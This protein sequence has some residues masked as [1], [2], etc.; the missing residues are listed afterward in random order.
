MRPRRALALAATSALGVGLLAGAGTSSPAEAAPAQITLQYSCTYPLI[1]AQ[2][3]SVAITVGI[4]DHAQV[5]VPMPPFDVKA[6]STVSANTTSGLSL[7][8]AKTIE[9]KA[10]SHVSVTA[11]QVDLPDVQVPA[12][13]AK[14]AVPSSGAFDLVATGQT[15][16]LTFPQAGTG[17]IKIGALDL[18]MTARNTA[19]DPIALPGGKP[20]GSFD[21]PC[22]LKPG[23]N[24][25]LATFSIVADPG[26][27]NKAPTATDVAATATTATAVQV[28]LKGQDADGDPLTYTVSTPAHGTA[29]VSGATATYKS[30]AGYAGA[31]SFT[32]TVSDGKAT[33]AATVNVTVNST[34][35][36]NQAPKADPVTATTTKD[37]AVQVPLKGSDPDGDALTY[38]VTAPAHGTATVTGSTASYKP[39]TGYTGSDSFTYKV[40]D[41]KGGTASNTVSVTVNPGTSS[42]INYKFK[43]A[44][45]SLIKAANGTVPLNGSIAAVFDLATSKFEG[46][47]A[48]DD[49]TGNFT[50]LGLMPATTKI[51][52]QKVG[53]TKGLISRGHLVSVS[54]MYVVLKSVSVLGF[55]V[56]GG[57]NCKT[58]T[59][60]KIRLESKA[61]PFNPLMGGPI[62]G[63]YTLPALN[64]KCGLLGGLISTLMSGPDNSVT[65][66]LTPSS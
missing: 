56:G 46:D 27:V 50:I 51:A 43:L 29:T 48:I 16:S 18:N 40:A 44:G 11:P 62:T 38:T 10:I 19:G 32:Y 58:V 21:A 3:L 65:A 37:T 7:I 30:A 23:Q 47:L 31:D 66:N 5:G 54:S 53:K 24:T 34:P 22:S 42:G 1:G 57:P 45:S 17:T 20:D 28:Q 55:Q 35:P 64:D 60:A 49:T 41:G 39:V 9:G 26:P 8:G 25:E 59:P 6:I 33:A 2:D 15:P 4:P 13:V 14:A 63:T 52:F 61:D 36:A 12:S